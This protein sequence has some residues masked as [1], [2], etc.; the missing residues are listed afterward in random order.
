MLLKRPKLF[1]SQIKMQQKLLRLTKLL[2][3]GGPGISWKFLQTPR[4]FGCEELKVQLNPEIIPEGV[5]ELS[6][7]KVDAIPGP[8]RNVSGNSRTPLS[9]FIRRGS[10]NAVIFQD[11][12]FRGSWNVHNF[13]AGKLQD[14]LRN[15]FPV[16]KSS[17]QLNPKI[18]RNCRNFQDPLRS[19][20]PE[21]DRN[22]FRNI[23]PFQV[24]F[25][26]KPQNCGHFR[27]HPPHTSHSH[28]R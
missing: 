7:R 28:V 22:N 1:R 18:A 24:K 21:A 25:S 14:P 8:P 20:F 9:H 4:N 11:P 16:F 15:N 17:L 3:K 5:L 13:P 12:P 26:C 23:K 19:N 2:R 27:P 6:C 10:W